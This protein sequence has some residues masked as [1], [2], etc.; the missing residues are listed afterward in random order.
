MPQSTAKLQSWTRYR[1]AATLLSVPLDRTSRVTEILDLH[2]SQEQ[3]PAAAAAELLPLV[4]D[5]LRDLA[6][7]YLIRER[8][9]H[10]LEPT[11]LVHE[12]YM[13]LANQDR[14]KWQGKTHFLAVGA[15][16]M[17]RLLVDHA[18]GKHRVKRGGEF[19]RVSL[20]DADRP[21]FA[22]GQVGPEELLSL[23]AALEQ[24][25]VVDEREAR[26]VELRF[27]AGFSHGE[28][29]EL[30]GVSRRTVED[31]WAHARVWLRKKMGDES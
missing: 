7:R 16:M 19:Q 27:F 18:R 9:D 13:R 4:Y 24:L 31:D 25:A 5:E 23:D 28:I 2:R 22:G 20:D 29:G 12:A 21:I 14:V 3:L 1:P 15:N 30:L 17:R 26:I 6:R 10:T 8:R 11:A